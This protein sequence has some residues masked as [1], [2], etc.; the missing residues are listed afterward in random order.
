M[1]MKW[2]IFTYI[3]AI[4]KC[5]YGLWLTLEMV[6]SLNCCKTQMYWDKNE[7]EIGLF[8]NTHLD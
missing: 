3:Q 6:V 2:C 1:H 5:A 8:G 7:E 4:L